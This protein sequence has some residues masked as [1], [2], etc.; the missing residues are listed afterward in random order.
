[1][2]RWPN[3]FDVGSTLHEMLYKCFVF[4]VMITVTLFPTSKAFET[5]VFMKLINI[6]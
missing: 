6:C 4:A 5:T 3:V 2:Q 1:M